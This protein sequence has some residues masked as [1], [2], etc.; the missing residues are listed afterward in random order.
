M[1]NNNANIINFVKSL[2]IETEL[3]N[4]IL[5]YEIKN[6]STFAKS[7]NITNPTEI[8]VNNYFNNNNKNNIE[9]ITENIN[10]LCNNFKNNHNGGTK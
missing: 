10:L 1:E 2:G 8:N 4:N 7:S 6:T 5:N 3:V 9:E